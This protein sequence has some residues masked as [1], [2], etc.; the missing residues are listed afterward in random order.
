M[1]NGWKIAPWHM[2]VDSATTILGGFLTMFALKEEAEDH[3]EVSV[4]V[5]ALVVTTY[6]AR[7][8]LM[9]QLTSN[10]R[11]QLGVRAIQKTWW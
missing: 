9:Q 4:S 11:N 5:A 1:M 8:R 3:S 2:G 10:V 7:R 6:S